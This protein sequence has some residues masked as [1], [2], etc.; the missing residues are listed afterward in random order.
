MKKKITAMLL[1]ILLLLPAFPVMAEEYRALALDYL[2]ETH[3]VPAERIELFEGGNM[4][5][6]YS[7]ESFWMARFTILPEGRTASDESQVLPSDTPVSDRGLL[8]EGKPSDDGSI[9][10]GIYIRIKTGEIVSQADMDAY[11]L[12]EQKIAEKEW[13]RLRKEAG[14]LDVPLYQKLQNVS[15]TEIINVIIIPTFAET[16]WMQSV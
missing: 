8:I 10:G 15:A 14:K 3:N 1:V 16:Q 6:E 5:L 13:E 12:A 11:F 9:Y 4:T 7:D 2:T